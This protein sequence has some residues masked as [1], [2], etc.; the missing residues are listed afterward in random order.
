MPKARHAPSL[1]ILFTR[2][3]T[4]F[5]SLSFSLSLLYSLPLFHTHSLFLALSL[6]H[7][8]GKRTRKRGIRESQRDRG[9]RTTREEPRERQKISQVRGRPRY[10]ERA[11][12]GICTVSKGRGER[13]STFD[14][15]V[16]CQHLKSDGDCFPL[17]KR[18]NVLI[19][20][21]PSCQA[22]RILGFQSYARA[23]T[24]IACC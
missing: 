20:T 5:L 7:S 12:K 8:V 24:S 18:D 4:L 6:F 19:K 10:G 9:I 16:S 1:S 13:D 17:Q 21:Y 3:F 15:R 11:G 22:D 23:S 2:S 14:D